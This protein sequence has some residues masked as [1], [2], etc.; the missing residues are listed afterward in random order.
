M[1]KHLKF[2]YVLYLTIALIPLEPI[3]K[4]NFLYFSDNCWE[5]KFP[6]FFNKWPFVYAQAPPLRPPTNLRFASPKGNKE[7]RPYILMVSSLDTDIGST[8]L[9]NITED[10]IHVLNNSAFDGIALNLIDMYTAGHVPDDQVAVQ[11]SNELMK[12]CNKNIWVRVNFN[13]IYERSTENNYYKNGYTK[14]DLEKLSYAEQKALSIT[15]LREMST[16]YFANIKGFDI[17]NSESSLSE[18]YDIW[19]LS[20]KLSKLLSSG[21]VFDFENYHS[22]EIK[23]SISKLAEKQETTPEKIIE[24]L[25]QIGYRLAEISA[26]VNPKATIIFLFTLYNRLIDE[27]GYYLAPVYICDSML[28]RLKEN[29]VPLKIVDAGE[30]DLQYINLS[31]S[32]LKTKIAQRDSIYSDW[33]ITFKDNFYLGGIITLWDDPSKLSGWVKKKAGEDNPFHSLMDFRFHLKSLFDAYHYSVIYVPRCIGYKP[34]N[35]TL[36]QPFNGKLQT[37]IDE[38]Y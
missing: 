36:S 15:K 5:V 14:Q 6:I 37:L 24:A 2:I 13:R 35:A 16:P 33:L 26:E 30:D 17:F 1:H 27:T 7:N 23:Y 9:L 12:I 28:S 29:N 10:T 38:L 18:F 4:S 32:T 20:L 8:P 22:R 3:F 19:R 34:F 21:L 31:L 11:K 25:R